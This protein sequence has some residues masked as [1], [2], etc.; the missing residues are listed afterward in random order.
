MASVKKELDQIFKSD[1]LIGVPILILANKQDLPC[2]M[3]VCEI[4]EL[5][6]LYNIRNRQWHLHATC[7]L[8][9]EGLEQAL[10]RL[11]QMISSGKK[12][13]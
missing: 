6:E 7:A 4:L 1:E 12:T 13:L 10:N 11:I 8:S 2:A 5:L 3:S 9:G